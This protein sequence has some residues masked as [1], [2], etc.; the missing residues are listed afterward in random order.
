MPRI[1]SSSFRFLWG[2]SNL[3]SEN[4]FSRYDDFPVSKG[5]ALVVPKKHI[6][7]FFDLKDDNMK[8]LYKLIKKTCE[9][10]REKFN[11]NGFNIG[12][13]EGA[14]AG[15]TI[16][17]L[18]IQIIPRYVGDVENPKGGIRWIFPEK[19]DYTKQ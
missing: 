16:D 6:E 17:H 19:A 15:R 7:S 18:H 14:A 4:F 9:K 12:V 1:A 2:L 5:H 3:E 10:I 13:N 8:E 11:P